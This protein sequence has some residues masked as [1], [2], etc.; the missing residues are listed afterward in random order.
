ME[1]HLH[2]NLKGLLLIV[3]YLFFHITSAFFLIRHVSVYKR[4]AT[5]K[6]ETVYLIHLQKSAKTIISETR[7]AFGQLIQKAARSFML[8]LFFAFCTIVIYFF[9]F[10]TGFIHSPPYLRFCVIRI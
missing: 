6:Q 4:H 7:P 2:I 10:K 9:S 5:I 8:L 1:K 3:V